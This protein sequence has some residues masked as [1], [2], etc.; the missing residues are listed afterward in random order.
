MLTRQLPSG[1]GADPCN[2]VTRRSEF[3]LE[4]TDFE[5]NSPCARILVRE[6]PAGLCDRVGLE[7]VAV[8]QAGLQSTRPR[9]VDAAIDV[10]PRHVDTSR[11]KV[12][13]E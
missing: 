3:F 9:D 10:D 1:I 4:G 12:A 7:K 6:M 11:T 13:R 8:F 2:W 5:L